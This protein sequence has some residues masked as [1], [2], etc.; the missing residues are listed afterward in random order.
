MKA[1]TA[2]R[3]TQ[4]WRDNDYCWA[5][6]GELVFFVPFECDRGSVDDECGCR[7]G[8]AGMSSH[9]ATSTM[10]VIDRD[11]LDRER[12]L[13][14]IVG[15]LQAQGYLNDRL[16][17]NPE[18]NE[19]VDGLTNELIHLAAAAPIGAVMERRGEILQIRTPR[20]APG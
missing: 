18:V 6:E 4:G 16:L 8:M 14:L 10:K 7:R 12:Y 11:D 3:E 19:W 2:T 17:A 5:V 15:G 13:E 1:L 20:H 9:Q